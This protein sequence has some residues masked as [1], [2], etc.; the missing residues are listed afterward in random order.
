MSFRTRSL[1][2]RQ[3]RSRSGMTLVEILAV[4]IILGLIAGT[5]AVSFSGTF[6]R[7]K[8]ELAKT[9]LSIVAQKLEAYYLEHDAWPDP[10]AG[11]RPLADAPPTS[12]YFLK[13]DALL[14]PWNREFILIVPGPEGY[15]YEIVTYGADGQPGGQDENG[16]LSS[17]GIEAGT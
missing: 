9:R 11:L 10:T 5:L 2:C 17:T 12:P 3:C 8:H 13:P 4:V 7:G 15:P 16:D 1:L 14:D 6:A